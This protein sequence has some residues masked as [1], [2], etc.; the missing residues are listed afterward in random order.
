[1]TI[2]LKLW[3]DLDTDERRA[4]GYDISAWGDDITEPQIPIDFAFHRT[5]W[6]LH[7][8]SKY[9]N[10]SGKI[11]EIT[12]ILGG[13][14]YY[15]TA[16]PWKKQVD[17][18]LELVT[19]NPNGSKY[20]MIAWDFEAKNNILSRRAA[21][22]AA[23]A[24]RYLRIGFDGMVL[25]Y[26]N[27]NDYS[28]FLETF[29][30]VAFLNDTPFWLP[31]P[32]SRIKNPF[33]VEINEQ[34]E[35]GNWRGN[36]PNRRFVPLKRLKGTWDFW[37]YSWNG[38]PEKL[39]IV[40]KKQVDVNVYNGTRADLRERLNM[41]GDTPTPDPPTPPDDT[42]VRNNTLDEVNAMVEGMKSII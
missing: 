10:H 18:F 37:Q 9:D 32:G 40:G 16:V 19:N 23:E 31:W 36:W 38:D 17:H 12:D 27:N 8:D 4:F 15:S 35:M 30:D 21:K 1:M 26:G 24:I 2:D 34:P 3:E 39:G 5:S 25:V 14:H 6:G 33:S 7:V 13:Y 22:E 29:V 11:S 20:E 42:E 41:D 28:V